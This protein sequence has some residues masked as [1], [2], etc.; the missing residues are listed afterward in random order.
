MNFKIIARL[1]GVLLLFPGLF[2]GI[3][4]LMALYFSEYQAAKALGFSMVI[5]TCLAFGFYCFGDV[6]RDSVYRKEALVVVGFGWKG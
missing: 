4:L 6:S 1:L 3:C 5:V 2:M